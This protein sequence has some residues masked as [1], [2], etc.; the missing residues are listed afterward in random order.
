MG[1]KSVAEGARAPLHL[2]LGD[3]GTGAYYGSDS[4]RSPL[5]RYSGPGEPAYEPD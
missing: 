3:V 4:V 2:L 5:D 1:M